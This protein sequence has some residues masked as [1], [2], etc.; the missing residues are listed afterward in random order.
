MKNQSK[1][2]KSA[3][4]KKAQEQGYQSKKRITL[5]SGVKAGPITGKY[6]FDPYP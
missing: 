6:K 5:R 3:Q 1:H 2:A 4:S